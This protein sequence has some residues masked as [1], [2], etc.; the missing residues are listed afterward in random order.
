[1]SK[2]KIITSKYKPSQ[3]IREF[4]SDLYQK[5]LE[6]QTYPFAVLIAR[7]D[8]RTSKMNSFYWMLVNEIANEEGESKETVH[9]SLKCLFLYVED[10]TTKPKPVIEAKDYINY[11]KMPSKASEVPESKSLSKDD[12]KEYWERCAKFGNH[13]FGL[14]LPLNPNDMNERQ[15]LEYLKETI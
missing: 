4:T 6:W 1:M 2:K 12:F 9:L 15:Y 13:V 3:D 7:L 11:G 10:G 8:K 14:N 5:L